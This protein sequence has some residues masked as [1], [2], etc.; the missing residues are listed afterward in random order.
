MGYFIITPENGIF[1][2]AFFNFGPKIHISFVQGKK[3]EIVIDKKI[4]D[5]IRSMSKDACCKTL[6]AVQRLRVCSSLVKGSSLTY[7]QSCLGTK[8]M[9][10]LL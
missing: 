10:L 5:D 9:H 1:N 2:P 8:G 3:R 7:K 6:K 4:I